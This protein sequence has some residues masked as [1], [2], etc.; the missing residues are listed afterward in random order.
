MYISTLVI[1]VVLLCTY[2]RQQPE[3][4][5]PSL[6]G[7]DYLLNNKE[8]QSFGEKLFFDTNLSSPEGQSCAACHGPEVG[9]TG[10]DETVNKTGGVYPGALHERH[11]NRKPNSSAY[12]SLAP[13]FNAFVENGKVVFS[14]GNFWDGRATGHLLGNPAAD[15]A[16]G[17]FL[18]PVE[19]N[20]DNAK[21]LVDKVCNSE[22]A[23]LFRK[24]GNDIW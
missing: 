14:G 10:P 19:Q 15:Q 8:L 3:T 1:I 17:P 21:T 2:C 11:G 7:M 6:S 16:Q 23:S 13:L 20:I 9:W 22:Y 12:A 18:N 24:V 4:K 5:I